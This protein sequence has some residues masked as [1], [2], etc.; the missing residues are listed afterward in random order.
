MNRR[1]MQRG[2][3]NKDELKLNFLQVN[4][5]RRKLASIDLTQ[6]TSKGYFVSMLQEPHLL[7]SS[8]PSGFDSQHVIMHAQVESMFPALF[9]H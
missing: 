6:R 7:Q 9:R 4:L 1:R 3:D 8:K 2:I 5:G